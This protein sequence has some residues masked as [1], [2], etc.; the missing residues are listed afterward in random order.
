MV[1]QVKKFCSLTLT[2]YGKPKTIE[3]RQ[4]QAY[5][6]PVA[7]VVTIVIV[8]YPRKRGT[9]TAYFLSTDCIQSVE[10]ILTLVAVRWSLE[11][12]FKD[13][14]QHLGF[15]SWQCW[16]ER[17]VTRSVSLTCTAYSTLM[18]WSYQQITQFAPTLWDAMPW[19]REKNT[20]SIGDVLFQFKSKCIT[21]SIYG[22][23]PKDRISEQ[24]IEQLQ[25]LFRIA[26]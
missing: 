23:L 24:K 14:K 13:M 15:N 10:S 25:E 9:V 21:K 7:A 3:Y 26:A 2:L 18:L 19:N 16:N 4:F 22:I 1:K 17:A 6:R 8:K 12:A 20:I 11:S 5:W